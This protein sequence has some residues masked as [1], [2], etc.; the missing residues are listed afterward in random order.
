MIVSNQHNKKNNRLGP[1]HSIRVEVGHRTTTRPHKASRWTNIATKQLRLA[2]Q[3]PA[4]KDNQSV[5]D[6]DINAA[7][8]LSDSPRTINVRRLLGDMRRSQASNDIR[9]MPSELM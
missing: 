6:P 9:I 4:I 1:G 7:I 3:L 8:A 2:W 5:F